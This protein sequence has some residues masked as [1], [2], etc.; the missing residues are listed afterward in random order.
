MVGKKLKIAVLS[1]EF[2]PKCGGAGYYIYELADELA[3]NGIEIHLFTRDT[4]KEFVNKF[5]KVYKI[6]S[7]FPEIIT[8][9]L[10]LK[11]YQSTLEK[12][13]Y[14][15]IIHNEA[16]GILFSKEFYKK[17]LNTMIMY[18]LSIDEPYKN[19]L[20]RI[21]L[22][23]W[24]FLQDKMARKADKFIFLDK[25]IFKRAKKRFGNIDSILIK[26]GISLSRFKNVDHKQ[27]N[28]FRNQYAGKKI[29]FFPGGATLERKGLINFIETIRKLKK[30]K[31]FVLL[32]SGGNKKIINRSI[33]KIGKENW[34][35]DFVFCGN[36]P[37][38]KLPIVY[39]SSDLIVFPSYYEGFGRPLLEAIASGV[40][41]ITYDVGIAKKVIN[42]KS[43]GEIA[44][45][46]EDLY[47]KIFHRIGRNNFKIDGRS[48][49]GEGILKNYNW[50]QEIKKLMT[51]LK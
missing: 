33:K 14:D 49:I 45:D 10:F 40:F 24:Q 13:D 37:Y 34:K 19:V 15:M 5:K 38:S 2:P 28:D 50:S 29:I 27:I 46:Q 32:V 39:R 47:K 41:I 31:D 16:S 42:N 25:E 22:N 3:K 36:L 23:I 48:K 43:I 7:F 35:K 51:F 44:L 4:T 9:N 17:N 30:N 11:K 8:F 1:Y 26:N 6:K 18:H 21:K 20:A 12:N